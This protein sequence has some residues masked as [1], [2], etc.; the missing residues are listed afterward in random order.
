MTT[1]SVTDIVGASV[2]LIPITGRH[3]SVIESVPE[4]VDWMTTD[5][6]DVSV[7]VVV[8]ESLA[9]IRDVESPNALRSSTVLVPP[10]VEL[11]YALIITDSVIDLV[12]LSTVPIVTGIIPDTSV[13]LV[14]GLSN[15]VTVTAVLVDSVIDL[16]PASVAVMVV[17]VVTDSTVEVVPES[18]PVIRTSESPNALK[19]STIKAP[20]SV[21]ER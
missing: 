7:A 15:P 14:W 1:D 4:S 16:V 21:A 9:A 20:L 10:S 6:T 17:R 12:P 18:A 11:R 13:T 3:V 8:P 5:T 2:A 19:S